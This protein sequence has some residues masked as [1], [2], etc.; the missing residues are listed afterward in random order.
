MIVNWFQT[1]YNVIGVTLF[2]TVL[3]FNIYR[4]AS[5][6]DIVWMILSDKK[7]TLETHILSL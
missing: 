4:H 6:K 3:P 1:L 2:R 5:T 7:V